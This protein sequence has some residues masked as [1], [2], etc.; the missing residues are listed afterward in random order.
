MWRI[1]ITESGDQA[2]RFRGS[3][4]RSLGSGFKIG[5]LMS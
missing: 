5:D 1:M 4:C 3:D 2:V